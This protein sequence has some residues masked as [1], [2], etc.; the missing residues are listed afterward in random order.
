MHPALPERGGDPGLNPHP[1][2]P[3]PPLTPS[4]GGGRAQLQRLRRWPLMATPV[5]V[6]KLR[7]VTYQECDVVSDPPGSRG[8]ERVW[9]PR[10]SP[11]QLLRGY[12]RWQVVL[13]IS[14]QGENQIASVCS[15]L[16]N[17]WG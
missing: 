10:W 17:S 6:G 16:P 8:E 11:S 4:C 2:L 12:Q 15:E 5:T 13:V 3:L 9:M 7:P 14:G 1:H